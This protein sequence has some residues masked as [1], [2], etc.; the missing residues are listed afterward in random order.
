M[1]ETAIKMRTAWLRNYHYCVEVGGDELDGTWYDDNFDGD[2]GDDAADDIFHYE[3]TIIIATKQIASRVMDSII[4]AKTES[5]MTM[6]MTTMML[7]F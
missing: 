7:L 3:G 5:T 2:N 1:F 6:T 4:I